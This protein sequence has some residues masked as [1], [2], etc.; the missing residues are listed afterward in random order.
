M[1]FNVVSQLFACFL[2]WVFVKERVRVN[3]FNEKKFPG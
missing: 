3:F 1:N 2:T